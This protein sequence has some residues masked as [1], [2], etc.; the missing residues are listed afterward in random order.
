MAMRGDCSD[1]HARN[2]GTGN[3]MPF[4]R[5]APGNRQ[6]RGGCRR[7]NE[8]GDELVPRRAVSA[9]DSDHTRVGE[10]VMRFHLV[11]RLRELERV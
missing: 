5:R 2:N 7:A 6:E 4:K 11:S 9:L 10:F 3:G 1:D 8:V